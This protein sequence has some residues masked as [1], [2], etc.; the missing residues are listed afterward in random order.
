ML[1][2]P[3]TNINIKNNTINKLLRIEKESRIWIGITIVGLM[4]L[5][6]IKYKKTI[7]VNKKLIKFK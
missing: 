1:I 4:G 6:F 3:T 7:I 2:S 5:Y